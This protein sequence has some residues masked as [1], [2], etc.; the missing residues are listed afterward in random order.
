[1]PCQGKGES[2]LLVDS[3]SIVVADDGILLLL[4]SPFSFSTR[5]PSS[6]EKDVWAILAAAFGMLTAREGGKVPEAINWEIVAG[7]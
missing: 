6:L 5:S 7:S 3:I 2:Q 1:M 4:E